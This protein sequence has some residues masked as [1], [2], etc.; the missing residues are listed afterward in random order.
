MKA[1]NIILFLLIFN[2]SVSIVG[3]MNIYN[4]GLD[5]RD[6][7]DIN[8]IE[9]AKG[10]DHFLGGLAANLVLFGIGGS[11]IGALVRRSMSESA[12]YGF[13]SGLVVTVYTNT[14]GILTGISSALPTQA[15]F[16]VNVV[17]AL[18]LGISGI[19]M[20]LAMM[21][22]IRGGIESYM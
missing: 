15:A 18:F 12:A 9:S 17:I 6:E 21:Q 5:V 8:T 11:I 13:F 10:I 1:I 16:M 3:G 20:A 4:M 2:V 7:Y 14:Y 22:L 19:M